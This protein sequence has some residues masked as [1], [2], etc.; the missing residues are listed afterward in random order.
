VLGAD[1]AAAG[2]DWRERVGI[3]LQQSHPEP[4]LRVRECLEL[5]A[6]Y[7]RTPA[8]ILELVGFS[9]QRRAAP[10]APLGW[11]ATPA[12]RRPCA[13]RRPRLLFL[14]EPT[15]GFDPPAQRAAW[16]AIER[17]RRRER[18]TIVLTTHAMDEA[19]RLADRIA[20]IVA[21]RLVA[22]GT[23]AT[24]GGR[25]RRAARI[26]FT[27]PDGVAPGELSES[28]AVGRTARGRAVALDSTA[29]LRDIKTLADWALGRGL[30]LDDLELRRPELEDVYLALAGA[31]D[32]KP[33][34]T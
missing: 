26:R 5:Y 18:M 30:E 33:K 29:P 3:V 12:R 15:T 10:G 16:Q 9:G 23:P 17:L 21:G 13:G 14:D 32:P 2:A 6:G 19:D 4:G 1:P 28:L 24:I 11:A 31:R 7:Y 20:V 27:L 34:E 22:E 25:D 8:E